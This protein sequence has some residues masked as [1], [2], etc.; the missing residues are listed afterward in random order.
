[1]GNGDD[2]EMSPRL[3]VGIPVGNLFRCSDGELFPDG[4]FLIAIPRCGSGCTGEVVVAPDYGAC[5]ALAQ[6]QG[7]ARC[8]QFGSTG[9]FDRPIHPR[10]GS[11]GTHSKSGVTS[12][13]LLLTATHFFNL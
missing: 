8:A 10:D 4:E 6:L 2:E 13:W 9:H 7:L 12:L 3:F 1:M 5:G 11:S